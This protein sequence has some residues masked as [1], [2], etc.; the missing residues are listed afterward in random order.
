MQ[1]RKMEIRAGPAIVLGTV[2]C[3]VGGKGRAGTRG[4]VCKVHTYTASSLNSSFCIAQSKIFLAFRVRCACCSSFARHLVGIEQ[5]CSR[6]LGTVND[7]GESGHGVKSEDAFEVGVQYYNTKL[8][9][10]SCVCASLFSCLS[11]LRTKQ[12]QANDTT[13]T[14]AIAPCTRTPTAMYVPFG[15]RGH[16]S[17]GCLLS[18]RWHDNRTNT[19]VLPLLLQKHSAGFSCCT[20]AFQLSWL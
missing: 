16:T 20:D 17:S 12:N 10:P 6:F 1:S 3:G 14:H 11:K 2:V 9:V 5:S 7:A 8:R 15:E 18:W 19:P 4:S 13:A